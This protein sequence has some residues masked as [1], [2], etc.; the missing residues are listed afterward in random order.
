MTARG[1]TAP[2]IACLDDAAHLARLHKLAFDADGAV[3][4]IWSEQSFA[5]LLAQPRVRAFGHADGFILLQALPDGVEI[6]T[7]AVQPT[8]RRR[9]LAK[10]LIAHALIAHSGALRAAT[11]WLEVAADNEAALALYRACGFTETGRRAKYYKRAGN[12]AVDALLMTKVDE[13][14]NP[15]HPDEERK[16]QT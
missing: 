16:G 1:D 3:G 7:L 9:G 5:D 6:L 11:V 12:L 4:Q 2:M 10:A 15:P 14:L 8:A 13:G